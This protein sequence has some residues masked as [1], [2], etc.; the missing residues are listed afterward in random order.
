MKFN[1]GAKHTARLSAIH[2][3]DRRASQSEGPS[4]HGETRAPHAPL[5]VCFAETY[6]SVGE[7]HAFR[8]QVAT[9]R[10]CLNLHASEL[11]TRT[12]LSR[13]AL[14]NRAAL[15]GVALARITCVDCHRM[16]VTVEVGM[17][18]DALIKGNR[19]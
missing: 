4:R 14:V 10:E 13:A 19:K 7:C 9:F 1:C 17:W 12:D 3:K 5:G 6:V 16:E 8:L 18:R 11:R 15:T 2:G